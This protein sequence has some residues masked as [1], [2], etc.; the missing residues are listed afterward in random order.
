MRG[1]TATVVVPS[2]Q[3]PVAL[4]RCLEAVAAQL[5]APDQ[6]VVA[7]HEDDAASRALVE[8][9]RDRLPV[10]WAT[11]SDRRAV[12]IMDAGARRATGEIVAFTDDDAEPRPEWLGSLLERYAADDIGGVG[13]RDLMRDGGSP[14]E[15]SAEVVGAV[16]WFG[17]VIHNH[18]LGTG[19]AREVDV[20]KGV[21][22]SLRRDLW[23]F[24]PLLRGRGMQLHW[25]LELCLRARRDGWR[26]LYDPR[27]VVDHNRA[28]R[29]DEDPRSELTASS[30]TDWAHNEL[31][32][33]LKWSPWWRRAAALAY[34]FLV[35]N[36]NGP[37]PLLIPERIARERDVRGVLR[38]ARAGGR[39]RLLALRT[40]RAGRRSPAPLP[41]R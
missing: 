28:P 22:M 16:Q 37:G 17:R 32:A 21:N 11:A 25:E 38:R 27:I 14:V 33:V 36:R 2:Y 5:R 7:L 8:E 41:R 1:V 19:E 35:G 10:E 26:L 30:V 39:G 24:D 34:G 20:L 23:R 18:H 9:F 13:G 29:V 15:G 6:V 3:R 12:S 40:L 4:R 31:Y